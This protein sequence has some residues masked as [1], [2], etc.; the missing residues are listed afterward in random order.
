MQALE[1]RTFSADQVNAMSSFK[2][3]A[4]GPVIETLR[5]R[6]K[7]LERVNSELLS[8]TGEWRDLIYELI[9][10]VDALEPIPSLYDP[11]VFKKTDWRVESPCAVVYEA[12]DQHCG[13]QID[14]YETERFGIY[15]WEV[16][17]QY[18]FEICGGI[19]RWVNAMRNSYKIPHLCYWQ[20]GDPI[21]GN[22]HQEYLYTNEFPVPEQVN[23][24]AFLNADQIR[25]FASNFETVEVHWLCAD[26]HSRIFDKPP[27]KQ[28]GFNYSYLAALLCKER[29]KKCE[30]VTFYIHTASEV[31]VQVANMVYLL[32]HGNDIKGG[33]AGIPYYG[34]DR[35]VSREAKKRMSTDRWF[36][37][38][39]IAHFHEPANHFYWSIAGGLCGTNELDHKNGRF[40][41]PT[42]TAFMVHPKRGEF[43]KTNFKPV[44]AAVDDDIKNRK[45][46]KFSTERI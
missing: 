28:A 4:S 7:T 40:A 19:T 31:R 32:H 41:P 8:N 13:E 43:N 23:R 16:M 46:E 36:H 11:K 26:N 20:L 33:F 27:M 34:I 12:A 24:S 17:Q 10:N 9:M 14:P 38:M 37:K 30:N 35:R 42:Q 1:V 21:S 5:R 3:E 18:N 39:Q 6:V 2:H 15:N 29:L 44:L 25:V 45:T 22:I